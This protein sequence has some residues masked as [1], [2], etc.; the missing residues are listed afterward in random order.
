MAVLQ[1]S[2]LHKTYA[3][4]AGPVHVLKGAELQID[5]G[6][7]VALRGPSGSGKSTLLWI[8]G[9]LMTPESGIV[10]VGGQNIYELAPELRARERAVKIGFV[11]QQFHLVPYLTV[12]ENILAPLLAGDNGQT[13]DA[14]TRADELIR[15]LGLEARKD[16][17]PAQLS[18]G[19]RQ[20]TALARA[21]LR[22]P[23]LLLADEPT[24]N[25]DADSAKGVLDE[26]A[27]FA[28]SGGAV[29]LVTHSEQA[30]HSARRTLIM[31]NG[32]V[33]EAT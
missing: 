31:R 23:K 12:R 5:A 8:A 28:E 1:L 29:L 15:E 17:V 33:V 22:R 24:G 19:E 7:F 20:R 9:A 10:Q 30:A 6:E 14:E 13:A 2:G 4:P 32:C 11:F 16:H 27:R 26:M 21:I 18:S 3:G 25:L